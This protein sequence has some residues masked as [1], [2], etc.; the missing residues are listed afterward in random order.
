ME[1]KRSESPP[2]TSTTQLSVVMPAASRIAIE[3]AGR[4]SN[5]LT[6]CAVLIV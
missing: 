4:G 3:I 5:Q 1:A 2:P 6:P